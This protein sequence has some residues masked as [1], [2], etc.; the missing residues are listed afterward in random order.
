MKNLTIKII[1]VFLIVAMMFSLPNIASASGTSLVTVHAYSD[2]DEQHRLVTLLELDDTVYISGKDA[3]LLSGYKNYKEESGKI[4]FE[5]GDHKVEFK[6]KQ[7]QYDGIFYYPMRELMDEL[8]TRYYYEETSDTLLF[9]TCSTYYENLLSDCEDVFLS[10]YTLDFYEGTGWQLAGVYEILGGMPFD[11][12]WGGYQ[13]ELYEEAVSGIIAE[14]DESSL[15]VIK[16]GDSLMSKLSK[17]LNFAEKDINGIETYAEFLGTDL[18]GI[19][20]AYSLLN[21]LIPGIS[22]KNAIAILDY[23]ENST[24]NAELYSNAVKYGLVQNVYIEDNNLR[25]ATDLVY[26][27][28]DEN[29]PTYEAVLKSL[30]NDIR[31]GILDK[32]PVEQLTIELIK[33]EFGNNIGGIYINSAYVKLAK[34]IFDELGMKERTTAVMQTVACR[35]IQEAATRQYING[36]SLKS[37]VTLDGYTA[38]SERA[39]TVKYSTILY[40][41]ACQYAYSLYEFDETLGFATN[42]WKEKTEEAISVISAYSDDELSLVVINGEF[43]LSSAKRYEIQEGYSFIPA[44]ICL[45]DWEGGIEELCPSITFRDD[46][47]CDI[48]FNM[49]EFVQDFS[50]GYELLINQSGDRAIKVDLTNVVIGDSRAEGFTYFYLIEVEEGL[51][52]YY[53]AST[54]YTYSWSLYEATN[55]NTVL[56]KNKYVEEIN[57]DITGE[58]QLVDGNVLD[59][60]TVEDFTNGEIT[61]DT[62]WHRTAGMN[63][64]TGTSLGS[65]IPFHYEEYNEGLNEYFY[66]TTGILEIKGDT[67]E[68]TIFD[69]KLPYIETECHTYKKAELVETDE[70][71]FDN[72]YWWLSFGQTMGT[73][74]AAKFNSDGTFKAASTGS[75]IVSSGTYEY[76]N[77]TLIINL[78]SYF[79]VYL[80]KEGS[81]FVSVE[82]YPM[83]VGSGHY[84]ISPDENASYE[85]YVE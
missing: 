18:D 71:I 64:V 1:S 39:K 7:E 78:D 82:E 4:I 29:K 26:A 36:R 44:E 80:N 76:Y 79:N 83:Q 11:A 47:I 48:R 32:I 16:Q 56:S 57:E 49:C 62:V 50:A 9:L 58:Y 31:T 35:N 75:G 23:V 54:G 28:Y 5:Y 13:R 12:L 21:N 67:I 70:G 84:V 42:Y 30:S 52:Q 25:Y 20:E 66:A 72:T 40:L 51:W 85:D 63:N 77:G 55:K 45:Q 43:D 61:F 81:G 6:N 3:F 34:L 17:I 22:L 74:Y 2:A 33:K 8:S 73:N 53:G 24:A 65:I 37:Y 19:I 27:Y 60:L 68:L 38:K 59:I 69:T 46:M 14:E 10:D 15:S 41:R